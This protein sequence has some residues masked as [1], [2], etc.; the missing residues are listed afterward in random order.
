MRSKFTV[1]LFLPIVLASCFSSSIMQTAK[2]VEKGQIETTAGLSAYGSSGG[3]G[4][5]SADVMVRYGIGQKSDI[6]A[7]YSLGLFGHFRLD[8]KHNLYESPTKNTYLSS[9]FGVDAMLYEATWSEPQDV[10]LTLPL[11]FSFN[12]NKKVIPYLAQ[13]ATLGLNDIGVLVQYDKNPGLTDYDYDHNWYYSGGF[14][15]KWGEKRVK[16]YAELSY[17]IRFNREY[18]N[19]VYT[20]DFG[21]TQT[22]FRKNTDPQEVFQLSVGMVISQKK[23]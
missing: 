7:S 13:R 17:S 16:W 11:Y 1:L 9:G 4:I 10:G 15:I 23:K 19:S 3:G 21:E 12:H 5:P 6:G 18:Q 14:G 2:P 8:Y 22:F 20:D